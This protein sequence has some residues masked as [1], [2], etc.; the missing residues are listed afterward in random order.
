MKF[1]IASALGILSAT[2]VPAD[3]A[4][5]TWTIVDQMYFVNPDMPAELG[6]RRTFTFTNVLTVD[7]AALKNLTPFH[8]ERLID[9]HTG[10]YSISGSTVYDGRF[11]DP[12]AA[13]RWDYY[14]PWGSIEIW[15]GHV[16]LDSSFNLLS[17]SVSGEY[18]LMSFESEGGYGRVTD[19]YYYTE[20]RYLASQDGRSCAYDDITWHTVDRKIT[21]TNPVPLPAPASLLAA[22]LG[23]LLLLRRRRGKT[24]SSPASL[25]E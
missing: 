6:T 17:W 15:G 11:N 16:H 23:G 3:A 25:D 7:T 18:P 2:A 13:L 19:W 10:G 24:V 22:G 21:R 12:K 4:V 14:N 5:Y 9:L 8:D 1:A 20:C